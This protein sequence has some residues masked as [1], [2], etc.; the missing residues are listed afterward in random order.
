[1]R[2]ENILTLSTSPSTRLARKLRCFANLTNQRRFLYGRSRRYHT[3]KERDSETGLYY[4]GARYLDPKISRWISGDPAVSE[5]IPSAPINEEARKR[6][7]SLPGMGG[8]FNYANLHAYHYAGNNPVKYTDPDGRLQINSS[9]ALLFW[10]EEYNQDGSM[11]TENRKGN[12]GAYIDAVY[13]YLKTNDGTLIEARY[14]TSGVEAEDFDCH[15]YTFT[16][17]AFWI[18]NNQ[19]D[20]LLDGDGYTK[21]ATPKVGGVMIQRDKDGKI[22]HSANIIGVNPRKGEVIVK[23]AV[24][25]IVF[26]NSDE[27]KTRLRYNTYKT[28]GSHGTIEFYQRPANRVID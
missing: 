3:G 24:G 27:N 8:V 17:G 21:T 4:Y 20:S 16:G 10:P 23:E 25:V 5:Y 2:T 12:S 9:G 26:K 1:M 14:N 22:F 28:D 7:G 11:R 6:N 15:G 18:N 13:G 19:I